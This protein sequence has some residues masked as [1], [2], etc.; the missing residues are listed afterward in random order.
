MKKY[1]YNVYGKIAV[2][3]VLDFN[4]SYSLLLNYSLVAK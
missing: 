2:K 4:P 3:T 1:I